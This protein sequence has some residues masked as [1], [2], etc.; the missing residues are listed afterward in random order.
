VDNASIPG[1]PEQQGQ[2][3]LLWGAGQYRQSDPYLAYVPLD[4]VEDRRAWQFFAGLQGGSPRW[5]ANEADAAAFFDQA[6]LGEF[7]VEHNPFLKK[8]LLLY[9]CDSPRGINFR[10][11]DT[12]WGDW[13]QPQVLF[14]PQRDAGY[15][16]FIH[17]SFAIRQCDTL[18]DPGKENVS[19]GEYAPALISRFTT[20]DPTQTTIYF[21]MSTWNPYEVVLMK[22][23]LRVG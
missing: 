5:S 15:C 17:Q 3:V 14:D 13:S 20:G 8:W 9:N 4:K 18:S 22:A 10:V 6:C 2:G 21:L 11:S 23:S 12:P 16:A 19:G 1:L 7:S